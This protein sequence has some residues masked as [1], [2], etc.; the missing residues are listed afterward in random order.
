MWR[1][2][3]CAP[4]QYQNKWSWSAGWT[5][6]EG[7]LHIPELLWIS[8]LPKAS[9]LYK[10]VEIHLAQAEQA[11]R[12]DRFRFFMTSPAGHVSA[13][14][15]QKT[16]KPLASKPQ[17]TTEE[18]RTSV[19]NTVV[20]P[21]GCPI[22]PFLPPWCFPSSTQG[23]LPA[24]LLLSQSSSSPTR[25]NPHNSNNGPFTTLAHPVASSV[26]VQQ[27]RTSKGQNQPSESLYK[28][29]YANSNHS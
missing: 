13:P 17:A 12:S 5:S 4:E 16:S 1:F 19:P 18:R 26:Q 22:D 2:T 27:E 25:G 10:S 15:P 8:E 23:H 3:C 24:L 7:Y 14:S 6:L 20:M 21:P 11:R 29:T 9:K 28:H